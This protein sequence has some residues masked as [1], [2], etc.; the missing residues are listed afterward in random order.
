MLL[1]SQCEERGLRRMNS[2]TVQA[3]LEQ[4]ATVT[5]YVNELLR[6]EDCPKRKILLVDVAIDEIFCNISRYG[7]GDEKG[8]ITVCVDTES[9]PGSVTLSFRD[10]GIPFNPLLRRDP[11]V[12]L[13]LEKRPIG[14]LG[15]Y[16][17][18]K[19]MDDV[20]YE[21]RD[22]QNVLTIREAF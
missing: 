22:G 13:P 15:I 18:K 4:L 5:E 6:A 12:T 8:P 2:I 19:T 17:L 7:Y 3:E 14:G 20:S 10:R 16:I 11:D 1:I 21:Y 9:S